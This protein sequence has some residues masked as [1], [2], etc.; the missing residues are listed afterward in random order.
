MKRLIVCLDGTWNAPTSEPRSSNVVKI[1]RAICHT[2]ADGVK[3]VTFYDKGV[4]TG[5]WCDRI[6]G[7]AFG[8]GLDENVKD[9]YRFLG[10]NYEDGDEIYLFGFSRGAFTARSLAGFIG[11]SGLLTK[12]TLGKLDEAWQLYRTKPDERD[13]MEIERIRSLGFAAPNIVCIGVWD[14][15]GALGVPLNLLNGLS[16]RRYQFHDTEL[17]KRVA[18]ALHAV[19]ID[20]QRGPFAPTLWQRSEAAGQDE[21]AGAD[22]AVRPGAR[23]AG[24][25]VEQVWFPGVHS[26][27]GGGYEDTGLSDGALLWMIQRVDALT[28]LAFDTGYIEAFVKPNAQGRLYESRRPV[29]F[30]SR[31]FPYQRVVA[32]Q[33]DWVRKIFPRWNRPADGSVFVAE[34][35][36]PSAFARRDSGGL[37][38]GRGGPTRRDYGPLSLA[39]A[40]KKLPPAAPDAP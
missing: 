11:C 13:P 31:L 22:D 27:V 12:H 7:G 32:Q 16:R 10:N 30:F 23:Q 39:A 3:Q 14:T 1:M 5:D 4:G 25:V 24:Q 37:A 19:A 8:H 40:E 33:S 15:V 17:G 26:N 35:V 21:P 34:S 2:G 9:G 6:F 18:V 38:D 20:E 28:H 36:H 29:Y